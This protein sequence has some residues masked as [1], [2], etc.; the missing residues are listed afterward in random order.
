MAL[1]QDAS[2]PVVVADTQDNSGAGG[3]SNTTGMLRALSGQYTMPT[4]TCPG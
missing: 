3:D 4:T 1:A 2:L